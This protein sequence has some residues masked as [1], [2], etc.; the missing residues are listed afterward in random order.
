MQKKNI[1]YLLIIAIV[2]LLCY[3]NSF[4][5]PFVFDD[6][7]SIVQNPHIKSIDVN[8]IRQLWSWHRFRFIPNLSFAL[9][10]HFG[11]LNVFGYHLVNLV[12]HIAT[13]FLVFW[14]VKLISDKKD[15]LPLIAALIFVAH[16]IHTQT[17]TYVAQR[18]TS[19]A[20]FFYILS[21]VL[22]LKSSYILKKKSLKM[23]FLFC[24]VGALLAALCALFS[25]EITFTLPLAVLLLEIFFL[26][27]YHKR[28]TSILLVIPFIILVGLVYFGKVRPINLVRDNFASILPSLPSPVTDIH[29]TGKS[30]LLTQINVVRTYLRLLIFPINQNLDYSYPLSESFF[31]IK[32]ILSFLLL[33]SLFLF[34]IFMFRKN[35]LISF[36]I[37]FF[38]LALLPESSVIPID[39]VIN[40]HRLYLPSFGFFLAIS[41][42]L[43]WFLQIIETALEPHRGCV[44][45]LPRCEEIRNLV[46]FIPLAILVILILSASF[47]TYKRNQVWQTELSLWTDVVKKSPG[48]VRPRVALGISYANAGDL[49][50]AVWQLQ[51]AIELN[52]SNASVY[53]DTEQVNRKLESSNA[54]IRS[55][56]ASMYV[57]QEKLDRALWQYLKVLSVY[58]EDVLTLGR[59]GYLYAQSGELDL[60]VETL[61]KALSLDPNNADTH[62]NLGLIHTKKDQEDMALQEFQKALEIKPDFEKAKINL[63]QFK[64]RL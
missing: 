9:N 13:S 46:R 61:Q 1:V 52:T 21:L 31:E 20:S 7:T 29:I 43:F 40:E 41:T 18:I 10:F 47:A 35:R 25:K 12:I 57:R 5:G 50:K 26:R 36:G 34:T 53:S 4:S 64:K 63:E 19:I 24:Y 8:S 27:S 56:L 3:S 11:K 6:I 17:V 37:L 14:F 28:K 30:Y 33:A 60:A 32:T 38:F 62:Y 59:V 51:K 42:L 58:P 48:K 2:G 54:V 55:H 44:N 39:D 16:P 49:E 45:T 23:P 22:Y 15:F